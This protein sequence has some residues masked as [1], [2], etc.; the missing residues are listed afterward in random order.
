MV[1]D[2]TAELRRSAKA[3]ADQQERET[4]NNLAWY[5]RAQM[6]CHDAYHS[7]LGQNAVAAAIVANFALRIV[8]VEFKSGEQPEQ[9]NTILEEAEDAFTIFFVIELFINMFAHWTF[10]EESRTPMFFH[11]GWN[12]FDFTVV[13]ISILSIALPALPGIMFLRL[14][15]AFRVM[16]LFPRLRSLRRIINAR[17]IIQKSCPCKR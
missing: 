13:A 1:Q 17:K 16:R 4:L 8:D 12:L 5:K 14:L 15:R 2:W 10:E 9:L 6:K 7:K 11:D 3:C